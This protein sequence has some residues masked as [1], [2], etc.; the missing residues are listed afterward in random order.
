MTTKLAQKI[1][2]TRAAITAL[3]RQVD[4][5]QRQIDVHKIR[6]QAYLELA[7]TDPEMAT[8]KK[9]VEKSRKSVL[10]QSEI[11]WDEA[12]AAVLKVV[13]STGEFT[14]TDVC[15]ALEAM[16]I[17][18]QGST[19]RDKLGKLAKAGQIIRVANGHYRFAAT[20]RRA[21]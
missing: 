6:L 3:Q 17:T 5:V 16:K 13:G 11:P 12:L 2:E 18:P 9:T 21:A 20:E 15:N 10:F 1:E 7:E 4:G 14:T 19:V 8:P